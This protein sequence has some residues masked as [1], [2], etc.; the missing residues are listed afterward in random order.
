MANADWKYWDKW[1]EYCLENRLENFLVYYRSI[2]SSFMNV[3]QCSLPIVCSMWSNIIRP[4]RRILP[5]TRIAGTE[6]WIFSFFF[7]RIVVVVFTSSF[8]PVWVPRQSPRSPSNHLLS[9]LCHHFLPASSATQ[10]AA[11][12]SWMCPWRFVLAFRG[13][14]CPSWKLAS[15]QPPFPQLL[16]PSKQRESNA[17]R[18]ARRSYAPR[19]PIRFAFAISKIAN[20]KSYFGYPLEGPKLTYPRE[21]KGQNAQKMANKLCWSEMSEYAII[22]SA[23]A[24]SK[25]A[26]N[27]ASKFE[28]VFFL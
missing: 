13:A 15:W 25:V 8:H 21:G 19:I 14:I 3:A 22:Y 20:E 11:A 16:T 7:Q 2:I 27:H 1:C 24:E 18:R 6:N 9:A 4:K 26:K 5:P 28:Y 10:S 23:F 12:G 17:I